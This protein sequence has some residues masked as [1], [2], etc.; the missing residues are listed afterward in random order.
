MESYSRG[1][2][3]EREWLENKP[4]YLLAMTQEQVLFH[5]SKIIYFYQVWCLVQ[6]IWSPFWLMAFQK[7]LYG[8][9]SSNDIDGK[10]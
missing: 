9:F 2:K 6:C 1:E 7:Q 4:M 3:L 8:F 5:F 10:P